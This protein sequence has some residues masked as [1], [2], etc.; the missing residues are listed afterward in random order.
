PGRTYAPQT[1][2]PSGRFSSRT[3]TWVCVAG[4]T[5]RPRNSS[6]ISQRIDD[7]E[8]TGVAG[9]LSLFTKPEYFPG[10]AAGIDL[11]NLGSSPDRGAPLPINLRAGIGYDLLHPFS[12]PDLPLDKFVF[13]ADG[14]LPIVPVDA[15]MRFS[16]GGEYSRW[17]AREN[18]IALRLGYRVPTDLGFFAGMTAGLGYGIEFPGTLVKVDYAWVPY[19]ELGDSHRISLT[20]MFG[21][22]RTVAMTGAR[23]PLTA[24]DAL[25]ALDGGGRFVELQWEAPKARIDG[26]N[27]YV[28][29]D[30]AKG[31]WT[32]VNG[33]GLVTKPGVRTGG[34]EKGKQYYFAVAAVQREDNKLAE[35]PKSKPVVFSMKTDPRDPDPKTSATR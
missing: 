21:L 12:N 9:D 23:E 19:G 29:P 7:A 34:L 25:R 24:P 6:V 3:S 35:S 30:P 31:P 22:R 27:V 13:G 8:G 18:Y 2:N 20:A 26:Y 1:L 5:L 32:R 4:S 17:F 33:K 11:Q 15:A 14:V 10:L 16:V 28:A